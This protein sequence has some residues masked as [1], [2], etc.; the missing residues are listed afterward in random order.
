MVNL[1]S[2]FGPGFGLIVWAYN[3]CSWALW[4]WVG[5][6]LGCLGSRLRVVDFWFGFG[7]WVVGCC[8]WYGLVVVGFDL[9]IVCCFVCCSGFAVCC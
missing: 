9:L 2:G 5:C 6:G 7:L 1:L 8:V 3:M 4:F